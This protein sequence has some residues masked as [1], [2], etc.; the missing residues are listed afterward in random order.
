MHYS[1]GYVSITERLDPDRVNQLTES[2]PAKVEVLYG[3]CA[4]KQ[5]P[6]T[7][8]CMDGG[9]RTTANSKEYSNPK[10]WRHVLRAYPSLK[11]NLAHFGK[12]SKLRL[13]GSWRETV[14]GLILEYHNVYTDIAC[15]AFDEAFCGKLNE[16]LNKY[17]KLSSRIM[18]GTD[19]MMHLLWEKS[20]NDY[21]LRFIQTDKI[22]TEIKIKMCNVNPGRF[23]FS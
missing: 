1:G 15:Q 18:F 11:L 6:I 3:L 21:L 23:I 10:K 19:H 17:D 4:A 13:F 7:A 12:Q 2:I 22:D 9:F 8:H 5:I 14:T 16:F 20:Y